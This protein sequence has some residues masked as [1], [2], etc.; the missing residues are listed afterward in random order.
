M[1]QKYLLFGITMLAIASSSSAGEQTGLV[2]TI[3]VR[4]SDGLIYVILD[5]THT[6][7]PA[8]AANQE[9]WIIKNENS[10]TG[11]KQYA[12][13]LLAYSLKRSIMIRG[14]NTCTRWPDGEDI[15]EV[16]LSN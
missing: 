9:Y 5:G 12:A 15:N 3:D 4:Q 14:E 1:K 13:L 6:N 8:C 11:A 16:A 2:K 7:K 10:S